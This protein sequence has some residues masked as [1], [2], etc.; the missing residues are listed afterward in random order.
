VPRERGVM[1]SSGEFRR[2]A[3]RLKSALRVT[4]QPWRVTV[5]VLDIG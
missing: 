3:K 2:D 5:Q 1:H 4:S